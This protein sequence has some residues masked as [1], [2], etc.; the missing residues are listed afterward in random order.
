MLTTGNDV[1]MALNAA[2]SANDGTTLT[3]KRISVLFD[4][5]N[6][7]IFQRACCRRKPMPT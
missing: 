5:G 1:I 4:D 7:D 6:N 2:G 3:G